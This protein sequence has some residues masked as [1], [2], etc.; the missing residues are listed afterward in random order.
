MSVT[1]SSAKVSSRSTKSNKAVKGFLTP[2]QLTELKKGSKVNIMVGA[3]NDRFIGLEGASVNLLAHYS[4]YA[5]QKILKDHASALVIPNGSKTSIVWIYKYMFAGENDSQ[6][7]KPFSQLSVDE[8]TSLHHHC[9]FLEYQPLMNRIVGRLKSI[10]CAI[11][12][13]VEDFRIFEVAIPDLYTQVIDVLAYE[14]VSPGASNCTSYMSYATVDKSFGDA[15]VQ[16]MQKVLAQR[17]PQFNPNRY[18]R[19]ANDYGKGLPT[20]ESPREEPSTSEEMM[21]SKP[22]TTTESS[23]NKDAQDV[24][25]VVD[26]TAR[27][28]RV[29]SKSPSA[30]PSAESESPSPEPK[31]TANCFNCGDGGHVSRQCTA[32]SKKQPVKQP[33]HCYNCGAGGHMSRNCTMPRFQKSGH[34]RKKIFR[35]VQRVPVIEVSTNGEGLRTCDREV[36][37]GEMTRTGLVV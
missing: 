6:G 20:S 12:P 14:M 37:K 2:G 19:W 13:S 31:K 17:K 34:G 22:L 24:P 8:L 32:E 10:F 16:T 3:D 35:R 11:L 30:T 29:S 18:V 21:P 7:L 9:A 33:I 25:E 27:P 15:L 36:K 23:T 28:Q 1:K 26:Y 5:K 4:P